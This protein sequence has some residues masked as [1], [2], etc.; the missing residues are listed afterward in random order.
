MKDNKFK[1]LKFIKYKMS[2]SDEKIGSTDGTLFL[3]DWN[4]EEP[5]PPQNLQTQVLYSV[6]PYQNFKEYL[7]PL[8]F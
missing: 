4:A 7:P 2:K 5:P 1:N 3:N 6:Y 8:P